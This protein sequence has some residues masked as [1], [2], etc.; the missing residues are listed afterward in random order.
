MNTVC[1]IEAMHRQP[2]VTM[3]TRLPVERLP[4]FLAK[5]YGT[6]MA[7]LTAQGVQPAGPPFALYHNMDMQNLDVEAGFP[8]MRTVSVSEDVL[9]GH[10]PECEAAM[11]MHVGSYETLHTAYESLMEWMQMHGHQPK[12]SAYEFYL[13]DPDKTPAEELRT[14]ILFPLKP[15]PVEW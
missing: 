15:V 4:A 11:C 12:G 3:R 8:V 1:A 5:A 6:I 2:T 9:A 14:R 13:N 7:H 10:I